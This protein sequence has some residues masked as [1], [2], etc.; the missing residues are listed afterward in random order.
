MRNAR[1]VIQYQA[2]RTEY[3]ALPIKLCTRNERTILREWS[4]NQQRIRVDKRGS[5]KQP[6]E[7]LTLIL[8]SLLQVFLRS[9]RSVKCSQSYRVKEVPELTREDLLD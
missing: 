3:D 1:N 4:E 2:L 8:I 9:V 7:V 6:K 5:R